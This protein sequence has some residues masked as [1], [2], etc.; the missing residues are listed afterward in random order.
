MKIITLYMLFSFNVPR[1][2][3]GVNPMVC[4]QLVLQ[5]EPLGAALALVGF[6]S[7]ALSL[8]SNVFASFTV[9]PCTGLTCNE[10]K[11]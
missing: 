7:S 2:L 11:V 4:V 10:N 3:T 6:F 9:T 5:T 8:K 1:V